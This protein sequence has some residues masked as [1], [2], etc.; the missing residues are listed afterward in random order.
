MADPSTA[1]ASTQPRLPRDADLID[2]YASASGVALDGLDVYRALATVKLAVICQGSV[3]RDTTA[4][5]HARTADLGRRAR[6]SSPWTTPGR[7][8]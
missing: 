2:R 4:Q 5:V 8:A 1:A 7:P 3:A 6:A